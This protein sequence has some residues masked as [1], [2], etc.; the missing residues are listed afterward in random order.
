MR[1]TLLALIFLFSASVAHAEVREL[2]S[3][4]VQYS[5]DGSQAY[6]FMTA[7]T[8]DQKGVVRIHDFAL[9]ISCIVISSIVGE[10]IKEDDLPNIA[11]K[12]YRNIQARA[13]KN[14]SYI[15]CILYSKEQGIQQEMGRL[16]PAE[17][18]CERVRLIRRIDIA[19]RRA[20]PVYVNIPLSCAVLPEGHPFLKR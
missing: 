7:T 18:G 15:P 17:K 9:G 13:P 16:N 1:R 20:C 14:N 5:E 12:N 6:E 8:C 2:K 11:L 10:C 3:C 19:M 4:P